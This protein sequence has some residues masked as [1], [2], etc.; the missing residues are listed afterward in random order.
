M[1]ILTIKH[2]EGGY[3]ISHE[4]ENEI[5]TTCTPIMTTQIEDWVAKGNIILPSDP[6]VRDV[7]AEIDDLERAHLIPRATREFMLAFMEG[8]F[9]PEQ[10]AVHVGYQ[11][12]KALDY[13][14][15]ALRAL[16]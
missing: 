16:L 4:I 8:T 15:R 14:I 9:T 1:N 13:Q 10:L 2:H 6:P 3:L 7:Q 5:W 11:K 12:G